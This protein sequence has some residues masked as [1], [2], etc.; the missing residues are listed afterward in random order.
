LGNYF[1][2][3]GVVFY[4]KLEWVLVAFYCSDADRKG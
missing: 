1:E 2:Q 4:S 3:E